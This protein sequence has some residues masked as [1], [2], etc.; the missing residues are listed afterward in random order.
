MHLALR[1]TPQ[2]PKTWPSVYAVLV[3]DSTWRMPVLSW[4]WSGEKKR[5]LGS[6]P[7]PAGTATC[8]PFRY[9]SR[10]SCVWSALPSTG[11]TGR[12]SARRRSRR[13]VLF[14]PHG[15]FAD[16]EEGRPKKTR[17]RNAADTPSPTAI[18]AQ[19]GRRCTGNRQ[20]GGGGGGGRKRRFFL[21]CR[22]DP[23]GSECASRRREPPARGGR[24]ARPC[25][26]RA[27]CWRRGSRR[28]GSLARRQERS[29]DQD[30]GG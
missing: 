10:C 24:G 23:I 16:G 29:N 9:R 13:C 5:R 18:P 11:S 26:P 12:P 28:S 19:N 25:G 2:T 8:V 7:M 1:R 6:M 30:L 3:G 21:A 14:A 22:G 4:V 17:T 20:R 27:I 15:A